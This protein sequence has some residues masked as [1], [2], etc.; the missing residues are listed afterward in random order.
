MAKPPLA[1]L[2]D[3]LAEIRV[4][5][6]VHYAEVERLERLMKQLDYGV[7]QERAKLEENTETGD[8]K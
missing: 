3:A 6:S 1:I 4:A 5:I 2:H 8:A 7:Q